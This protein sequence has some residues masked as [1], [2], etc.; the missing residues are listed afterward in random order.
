[1]VASYIR[2]YPPDI[3]REL[4]RRVLISACYYYRWLLSQ[5]YYVPSDVK[6]L[7][8]SW[9]LTKSRARW[10]KRKFTLYVLINTTTSFLYRYHDKKSVW[11]WFLTIYSR[12]VTIIAASTW[13][14]LILSS[15]WIFARLLQHY[16]AVDTSA[17]TIN[18]ITQCCCWSNQ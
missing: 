11:V 14:K 7:I 16:T 13:Q 3:D 18:V 2:I 6:H 4:G 10:L 5:R 17:E 8:Y 9:L 15:L 12:V 1:M